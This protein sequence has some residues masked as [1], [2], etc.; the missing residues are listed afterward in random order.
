MTHADFEIVP[1]LRLSASGSGADVRTFVREYGP[2]SAAVG[3]PGGATLTAEFGAI[4]GSTQNEL[5][6]D[7]HK[8]VGWTVVLSGAAAPEPRLR[9]SIRG[10]PASFARSLIQGYV[11]EPVMSVVAAELGFVQLPAAGI[12]DAGGLHV[13]IGRS[14]AGK[15]TLAARALAAGD[16]I[17]GDDQVLAG[18]SNAWR[19]FPRRLRFYPD[20]R[21]TAPAVWGRLGPGTKALLTARR[22]VAAASRGFVRP[23]LGVDIAELGGRWDPRPREAARIVLLERTRDVQSAQLQ[24]TDLDEALD[25]ATTILAEQRA[26]L[27]RHLGAE[28]RARVAAAETRERA[29]LTEAM[30]GVAV[31]RLRL[32]DDWPAARAIDAAGTALRFRS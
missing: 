27:C 26:R 12:V 17:I 15:S 10:A 29:I 25:W 11:V 23:S 4:S 21:D 9:I 5:W 18:A 32:P 31:E 20:I 8:T 2:F 14:R 28:W 3:T 13:L 22:V 24:A 19:P 6:T 16:Q 1:G 7:E 30:A